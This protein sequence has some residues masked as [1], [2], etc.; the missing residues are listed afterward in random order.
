[1]VEDPR[2]SLQRKRVMVTRAIEQSEAIVQ[3]LKEHGAIPVLAPMIAFAPADDSTAL[4]NLLSGT[5]VFDW[6][7]I[8]SQNAVKALQDRSAN[9]NIDLAHRM[10][11]VK[12]AVVGPTTAEMVKTAGLTVDYISRQHRGVA[13]AEELSGKIE[14][15]SILLPH[16]DKANP[17]LVAKLKTLGTTVIEV[18]AYKTIQPQPGAIIEFEKLRRDGVDAVLFFSPSAVHHLHA[19]LGEEQFHLFSRQALFAAIGPVTEQALRSVNVERIVMA[20]DT[21]VSAVIDILMGYFS[22]EGTK[23]PAGAKF[24]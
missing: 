3:A 23:L 16:S 20:Q 15:K 14:G 4:D 22:A 19:I 1:V 2:K 24:E 12:I 13:L 8:T 17:D 7:F 9:L 11:E 21:T 18:V 6:L 10:R 5:Q